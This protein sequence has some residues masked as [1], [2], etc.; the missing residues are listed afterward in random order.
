MNAVDALSGYLDRCVRRLRG[1]IW[2]RGAVLVVGTALL[3]TVAIAWIMSRIPAS[4]GSLL[5][6]R[7]LLLA[8]VLT[9]AGFSSRR[10]VTREAAARRLERRFPAF[11][12]QIVTFVDREKTHRDDPFLPLLAEGAL[13][14]AAAFPPAE[15]VPRWRLTAVW[16]TLLAAASALL[17]LVLT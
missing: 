15:L 13:Q 8:G 9:A 16:M 12:Q 17:L 10:R 6:E 3:L 7:A 1:Y 11:S 4:P 5:A 2:L 14:N